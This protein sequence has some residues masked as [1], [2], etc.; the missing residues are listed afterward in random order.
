ML[1]FK[2]ECPPSG[3]K[4]LTFLLEISTSKPK[5]LTL[6]FGTSAFL[7]QLQGSEPEMPSKLLRL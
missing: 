2:L 3:L 7:L 1:T 4:A 6:E 5:T